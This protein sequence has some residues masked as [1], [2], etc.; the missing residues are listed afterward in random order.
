MQ[1]EQCMTVYTHLTRNGLITHDP[2]VMGDHVKNGDLRPNEVFSFYRF[3][4]CLL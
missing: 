1:A 2:I 3:M 4:T